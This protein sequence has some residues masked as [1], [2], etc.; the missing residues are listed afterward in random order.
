MEATDLRF[1]LWPQFLLTAR[2]HAAR[3]AMAVKDQAE[4]GATF[5]NSATLFES[6]LIAAADLIGRGRARDRQRTGSYRRPRFVGIC[7]RRK[8]GA[9]AVA[10]KHFSPKPGRQRPS[11]VSRPWLE[12]VAEGRRFPGRP[13]SAGEARPPSAGGNGYATRNRDQSQPLRSHCGHYPAVAFCLR[14]RLFWNEHQGLP[15]ADSDYG[16]IYATIRCLIAAGVVYL[17]IRRYRTVS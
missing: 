16:T 9:L 7:E 2:H 15:F 8:R 13:P 1:P 3:S 6:L 12:G 10:E 4:K 17:L 5:E 14:D 11:G